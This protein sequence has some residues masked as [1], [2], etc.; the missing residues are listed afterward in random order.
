[1]P[2]VTS[3][4][5]RATLLIRRDLLR[6]RRLRRAAFA[7]SEPAGSAGSS[8]IASNAPAATWS[9]SSTATCATRPAI[10]ELTIASTFGGGAITP[11]TSIV[12]SIVADSR[13]LA[14]HRGRRRLVLLVA[15]VPAACRHAEQR[16]QHQRYGAWSSPA[17]TTRSA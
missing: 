6:L 4:S 14:R 15:V 7:S 9:P 17:A 5:W 1:M 8:I 16:K 13:G 10:G 11:V 12:S 2:D 3:R